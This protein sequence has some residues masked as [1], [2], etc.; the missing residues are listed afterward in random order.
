MNNS[1]VLERIGGYV[2][3]LTQCGELS[4]DTGYNADEGY[5]GYRV[6]FR[7]ESM[8]I[9]T[10]SISLEAALAK[11]EGDYSLVANYG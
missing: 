3:R 9:V 8:E 1:K 6:Q 5:Y 11:V 4:I 10:W 7:D 2:V